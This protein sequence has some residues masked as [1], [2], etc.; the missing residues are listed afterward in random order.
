MAE[1]RS[2]EV[3]T[4]TKWTLPPIIPTTEESQLQPQYKE[5]NKAV[6]S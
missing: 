6:P 4:V 1:S 2:K 5:L 3:S